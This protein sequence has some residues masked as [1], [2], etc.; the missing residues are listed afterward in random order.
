MIKFASSESFE[1]YAAFG[2]SSYQ[3]S[4]MGSR[5]L[6]MDM[7][8]Y[9]RY[10]SDLKIVPHRITKTVAA[11]IFKAVNHGT[12]APAVRK[13]EE[14]MREV[15]GE[16]DVHDDDAH[17]LSFDE[18][19]ECMRRLAV[20]LAVTGCDE[21]SC[22]HL[23]AEHKV[24]YGHTVGEGSQPT[25]PLYNFDP[26]SKKWVRAAVWPATD[27]SGSSQPAPLP[28]ALGLNGTP[29]ST[30]TSPVCNP[31]HHLA[32]SYPLSTP[33][34][35][36]MSPPVMG[37]PLKR[38]SSSSGGGLGLSTPE[39]RGTWSRASSASHH[40]TPPVRVGRDEVGEHRLSASF[41]GT[42]PMLSSP[43]LARQLPRGPNVPGSSPQLARQL[44]G[45]PVVH[46]RL[47]GSQE[48]SPPHHP[49]VSRVSEILPG[50]WGRTRSHEPQ[51]QSGPAGRSRKLSDIGG[52]SQS[53]NSS[54]LLG[55]MLPSLNIG[56][57][58]A[59]V[60]PSGGHGRG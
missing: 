36:S 20:R 52:H 60:R 43:Q 29:L 15:M 49:Q 22:G 4:A 7:K 6:T 30:P 33:T 19:Y 38:L 18:F 50:G 31:L 9:M 13:A 34:S 59:G 54:P 42:P 39:L 44:G 32:A 47:S 41:D 25:V 56:H 37:T 11:V 48:M 45:S 26:S 16:K 28:S 24:L 53:L 17:E 1:K 57:M 27:Y 23:T 10:L 55:P 8:E 58:N 40:A 51:G 2:A 21:L 5:G 35:P 14:A 12:S 46:R 3:P